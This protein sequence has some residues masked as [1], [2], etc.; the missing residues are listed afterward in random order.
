MSNTITVNFMGEEW[1]VDFTYSPG[2]NYPI[3]S[4]SLEPND[5][6]EMEV[7]GITHNTVALSEEFCEQLLSDNLE[8]IQDLVLEHIHS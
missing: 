7:E 8:H 3:H 1:S 5:P 4:A 2:T 6:E